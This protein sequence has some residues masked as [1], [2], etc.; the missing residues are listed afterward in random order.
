MSAMFWCRSAI[1]VFMSLFVKVP[2]VCEILNPYTKIIHMLQA[3]GK[4]DILSN[5]PTQDIAKNRLTT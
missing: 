5:N 3:L 1:C 2:I 4:P